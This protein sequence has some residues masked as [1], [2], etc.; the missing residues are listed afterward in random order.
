MRTYVFV[1]IFGLL[2]L[3]A[4]WSAAQDR[5]RVDIS[6]GK[7]TTTTQF[8][9]AGTFEEFLENASFGVANKVKTDAFYDAGFNIRVWRGL[10]TGLAVSYFTKADSAAVQA[11]IPHPFFFDGPRS[12]SGQ[13]AGLK[14]TETGVHILVAWTVPVT[15]RFELTFSGGPSVFQVRQD[16]VQRVSYSQS[17]PYDAA[18]FTDV[19]K[20][21][22]KG[23]AVGGNAG[24]DVTWRFSRHVGIGTAV[25]YSRATFDASLGSSGPTTFDVGGLHA[26][27]GLRLMF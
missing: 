20:Q 7:Q 15:D 2:V 6:A 11:S 25:R 3:Q 4:S 1:T 27:G 24:A 17:Y 23:H 21:R 18:Q 13:G 26:G 14:R 19:T 5:M 16:L 8:S 12:I 9:Q 10:S 22:I